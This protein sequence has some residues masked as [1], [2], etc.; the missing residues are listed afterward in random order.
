MGFF[1]GPPKVD[2]LKAKRDVRGLLKALPFEKDF[3]VRKDA[4]LALG[5]IGASSA[6]PDLTA[7]LILEESPSVRDA[8]VEALD[9][10]G[11]LPQKDA[12]SARYYRLKGDLQKCAECGDDGIRELLPLL[13]E[14]NYTV[15]DI[16]LSLGT[17]GAMV[18]MAVANMLFDQYRD[19]TSGISG[20]NFMSGDD[21]QKSAVVKAMV[22]RLKNCV[23]AIG[24]FGNMSTD[25][26]LVNLYDQVKGSIY[27][28]A[29]G[30]FLDAFSA[31]DLRESIVSAVSSSSSEP[32]LDLHLRVLT[33]DGA[34]FVRWASIDALAKLEAKSPGMIR[35]AR[36]KAVLEGA[37]ASETDGVSNRKRKL[38]GLL[39]SMDEARN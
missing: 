14:G 6:M 38:Q 20:F 23:R 18:A 7:R 39:T 21:Q 3:L 29:E 5:E 27:S 9:R 31:V 25:T 17:Q 1:F 22:G 34:R 19:F 30:G 2:K 10:L 8:L 15:R 26:Y 33:S 11:W 36:F 37:L 16:W 4:A 35:P 13:L 12:A 32:V 24:Q 28:H